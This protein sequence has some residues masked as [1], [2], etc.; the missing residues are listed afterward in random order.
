MVLASLCPHALTEESHAHRMLQTNYYHY[1]Y[2][3]RTE[4]HKSKN[5]QSSLSPGFSFTDMCE[6]CSRSQK[7]YSPSV[8]QQRTP[9]FQFYPPP[10]VDA[11]L[12]YQFGR[13][14]VTKYD[15]LGG[16][17]NSNVFSHS[18]G[19][20]KSKS[21]VPAGLISPAASSLGLW[22]ASFS[23]CPPLVFALCAHFLF[24]LAKLDQG[25]T[26]MTSLNLYYCFKGANA[27]HI[28]GWGFNINLGRMQFSP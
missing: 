13:A 22:M 2:Y 25:P 14:T 5:K 23:M 8:L 3:Y 24:L 17:N 26:F 21:K 27:S 18:S 7:R 15:R 19:S 11:N 4:Q 28:G 10:R 9:H 20:W 12:L 16:S 6:T 1:Y